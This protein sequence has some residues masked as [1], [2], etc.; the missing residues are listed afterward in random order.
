[1]NLLNNHYIMIV[2]DEPS[3]VSMLEDVMVL[4]GYKCR[5]FN[6]PTKALAAFLAEPLLYKVVITD[7]TMPVMK[8]DAFAIAVSA[9][10]QDCMI[11]LSTG[12]HYEPS[13]EKLQSLILLQKPYRIETLLELIQN[14]F[15]NGLL[16]V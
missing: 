6:E 10:N 11:I 2:D 9:A 15:Q 16:Q 1:M 8:G 7:L 13:I 12:N 14:K 4:A 3:I 5:G